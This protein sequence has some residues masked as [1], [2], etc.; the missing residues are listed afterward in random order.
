M[1]KFGERVKVKENPQI[2]RLG[3]S[4]T[5]PHLIPCCQSYALTR[6]IAAGPS[7]RGHITGPMGAPTFTPPDAH[8][9]SWLHSSTSA[10]GK[11]GKEDFM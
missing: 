6:P 9:H 10:H 8:I 11:Q 4:Q 2:L 7:G 5:D 1:R 3:Y